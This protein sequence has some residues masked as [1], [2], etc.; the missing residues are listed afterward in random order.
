MLRFQKAG[1]G[2]EKNKQQYASNVKAHIHATSAALQC[3]RGI[4][5]M[6]S[7]TTK[8]GNCFALSV[9]AADGFDIGA[10]HRETM[11]ALPE[12][13]GRAP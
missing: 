11:R 7:G 9:S 6:L 4:A 10:L 5:Q 13:A 3:I 12:D 2:I 8:S 1:G